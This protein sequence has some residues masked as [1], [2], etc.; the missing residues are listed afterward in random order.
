MNEEWAYWDRSYFQNKYRPH[1]EAEWDES[2]LS[3]EKLSHMS[4]VDDDKE[5]EEIEKRDGESEFEWGKD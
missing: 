5:M 1:P 3:S 2:S 4:L